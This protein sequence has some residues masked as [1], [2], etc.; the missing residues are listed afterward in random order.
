MTVGVAGAS[1]LGPNV[2]G[3][4]LADTHIVKRLLSERADLLLTGAG[5]ESS[6]RPTEWVTRQ[7]AP[8]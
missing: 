4:V 8:K 6:R 5:A 7:H 3:I 1:S 2:D